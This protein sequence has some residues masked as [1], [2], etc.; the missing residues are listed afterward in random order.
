MKLHTYT[1]TLR[2]HSYQTLSKT[3]YSRFSVYMKSPTKFEIHSSIK[4]QLFCKE[5]FFSI[6]S[7]QIESP[8]KQ[9]VN[10]VQHRKSLTE[11]API[12]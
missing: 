9:E 2:A 3:T 10:V 8:T 7:E 4:S 5:T 1:I 12:I 11:D 6:H